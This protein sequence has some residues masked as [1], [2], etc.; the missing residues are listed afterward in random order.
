MI[1]K[2]KILSEIFNNV[3]KT[4]NIMG[5]IEFEYNTI[6][7]AYDNLETG[8][9]LEITDAINAYKSLGCPSYNKMNLHDYYIC[10]GKKSKNTHEWYTFIGQVSVDKLDEYMAGIE[11]HPDVIEVDDSCM[12]CYKDSVTGEIY[13]N[14]LCGYL[15]ITTKRVDK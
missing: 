11:K 4:I 1:L 8:A 10:P 9:L 13:E 12:M 6:A 14:Y 2:R 3:L 7:F 5:K 15:Y